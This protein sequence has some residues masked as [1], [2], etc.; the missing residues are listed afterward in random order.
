[1]L[2][3]SPVPD[4]PIKFSENLDLAAL[5][6]APSHAAWRALVDADLK[7]APFE[8]KLVARLY[9]GLDVQPLYTAADSPHPEGG[10]YSGLTPFTRA[11]RPLGTAL[12]GWDIRQERAEADPAA[13]NAALKDD[14]AG[15]VT[16]TVLRLDAAARAGLDPT[17]PRG[18]PL[19][20]RDGSA[21][22]TAS[23]LDRALDGV[24]LNM[25]G[26]ALEAGAAFAPA[27]AMLA[28]LWDR[29]GLKPDECTGAFQADPLA[30]LARDGQLPY[31]TAHGLRLLAD[32]AAW[33]STRYPRVAA[34]RV[35][36]AAYH[37]A[38]CTATQDLA[39]AMATALEYLR[40]MTAAGL[41]LAAAAKQIQFSFAVGT[42]FFLAVAKLRAAR[43]LWASVIETCAANGGGS[44]GRES[45]RALPPEGSPDD[46]RRMWMFVRPSKRVMT[47]RD[48]WVN[49]LRNT[50][51]VFAAGLAGADAVASTPFDA[52]LGEPSPLARRLARN[53]H[54]LLMEEAR[55]HRLCDPAG[56]SYY[57]ERLTEDLAQQ[58]WPILQSIERRGGMAASIADGHIAREIVA[59]AEP[60]LKNLATRRDVVVGVSDF[61]NLAEQLPTPAPIDRPAIIAAAKSRL[62]ASSRA[63]SSGAGFPARPG[64]TESGGAGFPARPPSTPS[65]TSLA[66]HLLAAA[67]AG[68][69]ITH[70]AAAAFADDTAPATAPAVHVH[71]FAEPFER[72]R[73]ASD[74]YA[75]ECGRRPRVLIATFGPVAQHL[76]RVN[77]C[78]NLFEAGGFDVRSAPADDPA[79]P[80]GPI[81][82]D[83]DARFAV[84]CGPDAAYPTLVPDLAPALHR[85]G[86]ARVIL[87]GNPGASE[88]A[89]RAAGVDRFVF[90]KCDV[91]ALLADLL[92]E[93]GVTVDG[94]SLAAANTAAAPP[95]SSAPPLAVTL[96]TD[97]EGARS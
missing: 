65:D 82:A 47:T 36:T 44:G 48:P 22:Y 80:I 56:G 38:G 73:E 19:A 57:V 27:A 49:I 76:A 68:T 32:L 4:S 84:I 53:T 74:R 17:D 18:E 9:E 67:R 35:G 75:H 94:P 71:P 83:A 64:Q 95:P 96:R 97:K 1:M 43:R 93:E 66:A 3:E 33:T 34:V 20:A 58:A 31:S 78:R 11:A 63:D 86:A 69:S 50:V 41:S 55:A 10:G 88:S 6:P 23:D 16:S 12:A 5:F 52:T 24:Y 26:V 42:N 46:P 54:H 51:C 2:P 14:L 8:K 72:L 90:V 77:F 62:A 70:L 45:G 28:A 39:F 60:R 91:V 89:Y 92:A 30:V 81:L 37:H 21:L 13:L 85:A 29:R 25:I 87:A 61:P 7:G 59:A 40:A 15:G 79:R